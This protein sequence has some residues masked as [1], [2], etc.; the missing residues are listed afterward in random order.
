MKTTITILCENTAGVP[1]KI[2]GEHGLAILIERGGET[3][4]FD[5]GQGI[6]L[7]RNAGFL[8]KD[9]SKV[10]K[11]ALS[12]GHYDHTGGLADLLGQ[13]GPLT[14]FGHPD[15]FSERFGQLETP[16]GTMAIPVGIPFSRIDMENK[17]ATFDLSRS[18]REVA[19]GVHA[20]G[21]IPRPA[22]WTSWDKRLVVRE[23]DRFLPD[24]LSDDLSLL[25]ETSKGSVVVLGCAH[26]GLEPILSQVRRE[27]GLDRFH[28]ILGGT[29]L[30]AADRQGWEE[31]VGLFE[32]YGVERIGPGH[33]T[34]FQAASFL[35]SRLGDRVTPAQAGSVF[36]F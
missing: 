11:L 2:V 20:T 22:G 13:T 27:T 5:T 26:A 32:A 35:A 4:L 21:E 16:A 24:P 25:V 29:H 31:A 30:G 28:A 10:K 17:G 1:F 3:L 12:H 34:G 18:F 15:L 6:G 14:V 33:C 19:P 9:L 23:G 36:E 8:G 7:G